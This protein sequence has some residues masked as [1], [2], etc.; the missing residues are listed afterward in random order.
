MQ[1][2]QAVVYSSDEVAWD[3]LLLHRTRVTEQLALLGLMLVLDEHDGYAYVRQIE[4]MDDAPADYQKLPK[5]LRRKRL[6]RGS[7]LLA[8]IL[9]DELRKADETNLDGQRPVVT[10]EA[11]FELWSGLMPAEADERKLRRDFEKCLKQMV[12]LGFLSQISKDSAEYE[13]LRI[14]KAR[15]SLSYLKELRKKL[16]GKIEPEMAEED[17]DE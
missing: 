6:G 2:L 3:Q 15:I 9:R 13:I 4:E 12:D 14:I 7:T 10:D 5:L 16:G 17:D 8:V 11:L 1:L